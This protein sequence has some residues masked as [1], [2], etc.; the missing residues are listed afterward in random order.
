MNLRLISGT[1]GYNR[2]I[3]SEPLIEQKTNAVSNHALKFAGK[4]TFASRVERDEFFANELNTVLDFYKNIPGMAKFVMPK[5]TKK[6][7]EDLLSHKDYADES[8]EDRS[9]ADVIGQWAGRL[10]RDAVINAGASEEGLR[11]ANLKHARSLG[12]NVSDDI[13]ADELSGIQGQYAS[14]RYHEKYG[15][16]YGVGKLSEKAMDDGQTLLKD[17]IIILAKSI[18]FC[19]SDPQMKQIIDRHQLFTN[20]S[21][22][23]LENAMKDWNALFET[24]EDQT[25]LRFSGR[26]PLYGKSRADQRQIRGVIALSIVGSALVAAIPGFGPYFH[27]EFNKTRVFPHLMN[28][29]K[30][31]FKHSPIKDEL[32]KIEGFT[33]T[34]MATEKAASTAAG[35]WA[36]THGALGTLIGWFPFLGPLAALP[37][38]A[39]G[40][41]INAVVTS[42]GAVMAQSWVM[43]VAGYKMSGYSNTLYDAI[44][45]YPQVKVKMPH[46]NK[47][48]SPIEVEAA[49]EKDPQLRSYV[50]DYRTNKVQQYAASDLMKHYENPATSFRGASWLFSK[51]APKKEDLFHVKEKIDGAKEP[52]KFFR[53]V[54]HINK[55]LNPDFKIT[56]PYDFS[57]NLFYKPIVTL[58]GQGGD[59][60]EDNDDNK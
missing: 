49:L 53:H 34:T 10:R 6:L 39:T 38:A 28:G 36:A 1:L 32:K 4:S 52:T 60:F 21:P 58:L 27:K 47:L 59:F 55:V 33:Q 18:Q 26:T 37:A 41:A 17:G 43:G 7:F 9:D 56:V 51:P 25:Q 50:G 54:Y 5:E 19:K 30:L 57:K 44:E 35:A 12:L 45:D 24:V 40:V 3:K 22:A 48:L 42:I 16:N 8:I 15:H 20:P 23:N 31:N 2:P 11:Q 46:G 14:H 13:S 29:Y